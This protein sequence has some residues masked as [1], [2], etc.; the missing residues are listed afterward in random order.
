MALSNNDGCA[1]SRS[2]EAR[3]MS[4][5]IWHRWLEMR[6]LEDSEGLVALSANFALY[7]DLRDRDASITRALVIERKFTRLMSRLSSCCIRGDLGLRGK[8]LREQILKWIGVPCGIGIGSLKTLA[9][10][11]NHAAKTTEHKPGT[12][13][14]HLVRVCNLAALTQSELDSA[15]C[16]PAG[17]IWGLEKNV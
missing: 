8:K 6:H 15:R 9:K 3:S 13:P 4:I 16:N 10:L 17:D 1:N 2:N 11:A 14:L 7:G 12:P 5:H